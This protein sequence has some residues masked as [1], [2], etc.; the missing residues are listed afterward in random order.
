MPTVFCHAS[1]SPHRTAAPALRTRK[2]GSRAHSA[3]A[4][5]ARAA[6]RALSTRASADGALI[7][8]LDL[9]KLMEPIVQ[10]KLH[11]RF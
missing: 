3:N 6:N 1:D 5:A 10:G 8:P 11:S 4:A 9:M 2:N 7:H